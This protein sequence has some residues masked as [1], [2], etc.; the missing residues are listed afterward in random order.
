MYKHP[1]TT[2]AT[3]YS[4]IGCGI[5]THIGDVN[6]DIGSGEALIPGQLYVSI[7]RHVPP[8]GNKD[9]HIP[10]VRSSLGGLKHV[11]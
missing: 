8:G 7:V 1:I 5:F 10:E 4:S 11:G 2:T 6:D 3:P 9:G